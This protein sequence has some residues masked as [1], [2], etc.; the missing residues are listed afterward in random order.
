MLDE[1][2]LPIQEVNVY[3]IGIDCCGNIDNDVNNLD[4][5]EELIKRNSLKKPTD[6]SSSHRV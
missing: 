1:H 6:F 3:T 2:W 4:L 5:T